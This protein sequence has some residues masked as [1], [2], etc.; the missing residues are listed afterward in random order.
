MNKI[1]K[2]ITI[3]LLITYISIQFI[4]S[5]AA[6]SYYEDGLIKTIKI[7]KTGNDLSDP[8]IE[9]GSS[10]SIT[11]TFDDLSDNPIAYSYTL[12]HC[13]S[14]WEESKIIKSDYMEGFETNSIND[15][16]NSYSTTV[17]YT[18]Y[19]LQIPNNDVK[20]KLS[21]NY[22]IKVF[23]TN[24]YENIAFEQRFMVVENILPLNASI[25]QPIDSESRLTSQQIELTVTTSPLNISNPYTDLT[26]VALQN[27]QPQG[28]FFGIKPT[29]IKS[30]EIAYSSP[31]NLIFNGVNEFRSFNINSIRFISSGIQSIDLVG[32]T[33]NVLLLPSENNRKQKYSSSE[34]INGRCKINLERSEQSDIEADYI[35]VY[36]TLPYYDQL[37]EKEVFVYGELTDWQLT[38]QSKMNY[39]YQRSAYELRLQLK[40]GYYNYRYVVKDIKTGEID[41]A[42]FEGNHFE[43]EN[44]YLILAY[45]KCVGL[46]YERLVGIKKLN[47]RSSI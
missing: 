24:N 7:H 47:S 27:G 6:S 18:H 32:G 33:Y 37:P 16:Q 22:I 4:N 25:R 29:F 44:D 45:Y 11:L 23:D 1:N 15:Y 5:Y 43:T 21:G 42:F 28:S 14:N 36:F 20:I 13:S 2:W 34:D 40:Q 9:L 30:N 12:I 26:I 19:K 35:W 3:Y 8:I 31:D 39:N 41:P 46:R 10:E 38:S 17:P